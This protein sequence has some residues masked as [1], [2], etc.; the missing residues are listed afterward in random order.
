MPCYMGVTLTPL[1]NR[2][3]AQELIDR[4]GS[5][6]YYMGTED[7]KIKLNHPSIPMITIYLDVF[8]DSRFKSAYC[9]N[10][11]GKSKELLIRRGNAYKTE[12]D[13][14]GTQ[15]SEGVHQRDKEGEVSEE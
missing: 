9:H 14:S 10:P 7:G 5:Y 4:L 12:R 3:E 11:T 15:A 13:E 8:K 2:R 1:A 6:W